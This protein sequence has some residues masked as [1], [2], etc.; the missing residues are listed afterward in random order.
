VVDTADLLDKFWDMHSAV[1][2]P[3]AGGINS[4]TWL[5]EHRGS[6]YVA[7]RVSPEGVA[8]LVAGCEVAA[9][10]AQDGFRHGTT[11]AHL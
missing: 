11:S 5:V 1:V 2:R 4:E 9:A 10:L 7:K 6:T 3:L 8:D